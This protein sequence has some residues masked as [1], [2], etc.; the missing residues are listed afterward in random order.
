MNAT[1]ICQRSQRCPGKR[2]NVKQYMTVCDIV[3][4]CM[5]VFGCDCAYLIGYDSQQKLL[6][7]DPAFYL[8]A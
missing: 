7:F 3:C 1:V 4:Q 5:T 8:A 6:W 2:D